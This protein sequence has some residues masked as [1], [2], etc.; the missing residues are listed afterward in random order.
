MD[1][2]Y[3][4]T[5]LTSAYRFDRNQFDFQIPSHNIADPASRLTSYVESFPKDD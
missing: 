3:C 5:G 4:P 2:P 1:R